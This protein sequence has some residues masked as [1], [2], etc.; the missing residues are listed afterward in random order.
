MASDKGLLMKPP[1]KDTLI[2]YLSEQGLRSIDVEQIYGASDGRLWI[3]TDVGLDVFHPEETSFQPV[4]WD[5]LENTALRTL[6]EQENG[7]L[8]VGTDDGLYQVDPSAGATRRIGADGPML[9]SNQSIHAI[10]QGGDGRLYVGTFDGLNALDFIK[11]E[12]EIFHSESSSSQYLSED[13]I[14]RLFTDRQGLLWVGTWGKELQY[15]DFQPPTFQH[16]LVPF[17]KASNINAIQ[18]TDQALW[19]GT[20]YGGLIR[21]DYQTEEFNQWSTGNGLSSFQVY[22]LELWKNKVWAGKGFK[23]F[24]TAIDPETN[25]LINYTPEN[26]DIPDEEIWAMTIDQDNHL[27]VAGLR[28]IYE[29]KTVDTEGRLVLGRQ[30]TEVRDTTGEVFE[31]QPRALTVDKNNHLWVGT[32]DKGL[33]QFD[34]STNTFTH[35]GPDPEDPNSCPGDYINTVYEDSKGQIWVGTAQGAGR[36]DQAT[37]QFTILS[38]EDGLPNNYV[39]SILEDIPGRFWLTTN[40][41]LVQYLGEGEPMRVFTDREGLPVNEFNK[42]AG[43]LSRGLIYYGTVE[44]MVMANPQW[45]SQ[46]PYI[47]PVVITKLTYRNRR[48]NA[49]AVAIAGI[50]YRDEIRLKYSENILEINFAAL[51]YLQSAKNRYRYQLQGF[52]KNWVELGESRNITLSGL[53]PALYTLIVQGSNNDGVWNEVGS[54]LK[55]RI[56]PPFWLTNWAFFFYIL[57]GILLLVYTY[58]YMLRKQVAKEEA[59]QQQELE[60]AK[61][62]FFTNIAHEFKNPLT[63]IFSMAHELEGNEEARAKIIRYGS[64]I[65]R[66]VNQVLDLRR[67]ENRQL[68]IELV[69]LDIIAYSRQILTSF[70][71]LARQNSVQLQFNAEDGFVMMDMDR[72]K[73]QA[74][75]YNLISNAIKYNKN[76]GVVSI[77]VSTFYKEDEEFLQVLVRDTGLGIP[78]EALS[79]IFDRFYQVDHSV[80]TVGG[81]GVGLSL[82]KELVHL[83]GGTIFVESKLGEGSE[84]VVHLP[85]HKEARV[86]YS[87]TEDAGIVLPA[88][89]QNGTQRSS[90]ENT[91]LLVEDNREILQFLEKK[92]A[93]Y[94]RVLKAIDGAEGISIAIEEIPDLIISD[95]MMPKKDGIELLE[96]LKKDERTSH[97]PIILLTAKSAVEDRIRGLE[98]GADRY[99]R[100]PFII[101]ELWAHIR[102]LLGN[103]KKM[104]RHF[105][106]Q[107]LGVEL[108]EEPVDPFLSKAQQTVMDHLEDEDFNASQLW[109]VLNISRTNLYQKLTALTGKS[110]SHFIRD[111][112]LVEGRKLLLT[113]NLNISEVAY[114]VG[115]KDPGY[116]T[117][118]YKEFFNETPSDTRK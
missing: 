68:P 96:T 113:T 64:D 71:P 38:E 72:D 103:R 43:L 37:G 109:K 21:Y 106:K 94:F 75:L 1:G 93:Q 110:A 9:L 47:P 107:L 8:W 46:N 13:R 100:K 33:L 16:L 34:L 57:S 45:I 26:S 85:V 19:L 31:I 12:N 86:F 102:S 15:L 25:Q 112:R 4:E 61:M 117:T 14:S 89:S 80:R 36:L 5:F 74:I 81:T 18:H 99:L 29:I 82:V 60:E 28:S 6:Y 55:I 87:Q 7:L 73:W 35:F 66:L 98:K 17:A 77:D 42:N 62:R 65:R 70:E 105:Q 83:L 118:C 53:D 88:L 50:T 3:K 78:E 2:T 63:M 90:V 116:F 49:P 104:Q 76:E 41:G 92:F 30:Y 97:I 11:G 115:F 27:W 56:T 39:F 67:L 54:S 111:I 44:G 40:R 24:L 10:E 59:K 84:F 23:G 95:V 20:E 91:L 58:R 101:D 32:S 52:S 79:Q 48:R 108:S 114:Q 22:A 51:N 69:Q